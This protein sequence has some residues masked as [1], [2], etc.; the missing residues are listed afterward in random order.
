ML[1]SLW[2]D[3]KSKVL[4][5]EEIEYIERKTLIEAAKHNTPISRCEADFVDI[6]KLIEDIPAADVRP[7]KHG[8]WK[9]ER[10]EILPIK[11]RDLRICNIC[12][13]WYDQ[14]VTDGVFTYCPN[15][16]AK[17]DGKF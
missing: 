7:E 4:T 10:K 14:D 13:C 17:M 1:H 2:Q 5:M 16:G 11:I 15:C 3:K 9:K 8:Y 6:K 12:G